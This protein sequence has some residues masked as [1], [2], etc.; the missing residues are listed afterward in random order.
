MDLDTD[1]T[2]AASSSPGPRNASASTGLP[3]RET[4]SVRSCGRARAASATSAQGSACASAGAARERPRPARTARRVGRGIGGSC[5]GHPAVVA[6]GAPPSSQPAV[7]ISVILEL[8]HHVPPFP[9]RDHLAVREAD[10]MERPLDLALP[11]LDELEEARMVGR[12]VVVLPDEAVED[13]AVIR[14]SGRRTR[15]SSGRSLGASARSP[16]RAV[17]SWVDLLGGDSLPLRGPVITVP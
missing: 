7:S 17:S 6:P 4:W 10:G 1:L 2:F 3:F 11:E 16:R 12:E 14:A 5:G 13:V 15:P 8:A 9:R